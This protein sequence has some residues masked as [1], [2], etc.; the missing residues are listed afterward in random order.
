MDWRER[1]VADP[2][3]MVGKP[4]VKGTRLTEEHLIDQLANGWSEADL[5]AAYPG[6]HLNSGSRMGSSYFGT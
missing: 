4:V 6:L 5:L 3:V 1:I 2:L